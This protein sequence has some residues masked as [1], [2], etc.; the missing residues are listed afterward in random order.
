MTEDTKHSAFTTDQLIW[1]VA[2]GVGLGPGFKEK[3][4]VV[5][6]TS[7]KNT[8]TEDTCHEE[9]A[10]MLVCNAQAPCNYIDGQFSTHSF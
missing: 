1:N 8:R 10:Q 3:L 2:S 5:L 7:H 4:E 9:A 6:S